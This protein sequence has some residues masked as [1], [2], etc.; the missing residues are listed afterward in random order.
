MKSKSKHIEKKYTS[1]NTSQKEST[2]KFHKFYLHSLQ[3]FAR[4]YC[5]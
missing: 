2:N 5:F 3:T 4:R 1:V